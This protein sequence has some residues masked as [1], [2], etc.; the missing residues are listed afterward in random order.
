MGCDTGCPVHVRGAVLPLSRVDRYLLQWL[1]SVMTRKRMQRRLWLLKCS[2]TSWNPLQV[3]CSLIL[4][5]ICELCGTSFSPTLSLSLVSECLRIVR[6]RPVCSTPPLPL[7][8][9]THMLVLL[10][11]S[12]TLPYLL[13][14]NS[15]VLRAPPPDT[16]GAVAPDGTQC[17][18]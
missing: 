7:M 5:W 8:Y 12:L 14:L 15:K 17:Q 11:P 9:I 10:V 18:I 6:L 13:L 16:S 4:E 2:E 1:L 3:Q